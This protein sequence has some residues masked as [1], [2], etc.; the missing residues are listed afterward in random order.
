MIPYDDMISSGSTIAKSDKAI[1]ENG[2]EIWG[3][4][5]THGL[6][7][8]GINENLDPDTIPRVIIS[9]TVLPFRLSEKVSKKVTVVNTTTLF[10]E[11]I[12]RIHSGTGSIS[13]LLE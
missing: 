8:G 12:Y 5:S 4:C 9:D 2:G 7:V 10:A 6:C 3:V 13:D 11:A 1:R